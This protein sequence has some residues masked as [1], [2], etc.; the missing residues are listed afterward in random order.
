VP[1]Y[2]GFAPSRKE[3]L[4]ILIKAVIHGAITSYL[5]FHSLIP[6]VF[7]IPFWRFYK[8]A[9]EKRLEEKKKFLFETQFTDAIGCLSGVL[10]GGYSVENAITQTRRDLEFSYGKDSMIMKEL[11]L[12]E[13]QLRN[14]IPIED[15]FRAMAKR[16]GCE[17][18]RSF[19]DVFSTAKRTGGNII[20]IIRTTSDTI[21][22]KNEVLREN[23][24]V[25]AAKKLESDIMNRIPY[26]MLAYLNLSSPEL[27]KFLY[28]N[29]RGI[30]FMT[31]MLGAYIGFAFLSRNIVRNATE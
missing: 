19:S 31:A 10:E 26:A 13:A 7:G 8:K 17:D 18:V 28:G 15:A 24:T 9:Q 29:V 20:A 11:V 5:F 25:M 16:T 2:E 21:R 4:L 30:L 23:K 12:I 14:N 6:I 22:S 3:K 27:I 1:V